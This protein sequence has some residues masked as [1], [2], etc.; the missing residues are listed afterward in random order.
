MCSMRVLIERS[1]S[2][3]LFNNYFK[4]NADDILI[5]TGMNQISCF[6]F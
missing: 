2:A 1:Q 3:K 5:I 4:L 6:A